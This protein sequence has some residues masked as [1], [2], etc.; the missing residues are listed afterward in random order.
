ML[1]VECLA[2]CWRMEVDWSDGA[3]VMVCGGDR[4]MKG[5]LCATDE[6]SLMVC[7]R[8]W[9]LDEWRNRG[10][11]VEETHAPLDDSRWPLGHIRD[12][13]DLLNVEVDR[14][15]EESKIRSI[16]SHLFVMGHDGRSQ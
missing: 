6:D 13:R 3:R 15:W 8:S 12:G 16:S 11:F 2:P 10:R 4:E 14:A 5:L 1:P 9:C 7:S